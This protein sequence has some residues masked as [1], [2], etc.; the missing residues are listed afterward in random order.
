MSTTEREALCLKWGVIKGWDFK[1][2]ETKA[3]AQKYASYGWSESA[4]AHVVCAVVQLDSGRLE[5]VNIEHLQ[6]VSHAL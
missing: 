3:L 1:R 2:E 5:T 4:M 6:V